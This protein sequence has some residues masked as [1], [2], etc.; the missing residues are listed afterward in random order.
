MKIKFENST[1]IHAQ[2]FIGD[3]SLCGLA[4]DG[5]DEL[6]LAESATGK[7]NCEDCITALK[8]YKRFK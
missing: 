8:Y 1:T 2:N 6:G 7:I 4:I 5:A 3:A